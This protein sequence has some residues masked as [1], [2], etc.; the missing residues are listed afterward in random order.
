[1]KEDISKLQNEIGDLG[2]LSELS[3]EK[4]FSMYK[5]DSKYFA[6]NLLRTIRIPRDLNEDIYFYTRISGNSTWVQL[7][8]DFYG[9]IR[10][11]WL[12]CITNGILNPVELPDPGT[13]IKVIK[14]TYVKSVINSI[15]SQ[16]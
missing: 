2:S 13:V 5:D 12:I 3:Y 10:L 8:Y 7:S 11:W 4:I 16:V 9:N 14:P 15:N 1:M 6:Y